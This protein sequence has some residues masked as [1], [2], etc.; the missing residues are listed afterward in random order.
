[1]KKQ[2]TTTKP[3]RNRIVVRLH[4]LRSRYDAFA[5]GSEEIERRSGKAPRVETMMEY[6]LETNVDPDDLADLYC[7]TVLKWSREKIDTFS[8]HHT[9]RPRVRKRR[10]AKTAGSLQ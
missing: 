4:I 2:A 9:G 5:M 6:D 7:W 1:M 3:K 10:D 8:N